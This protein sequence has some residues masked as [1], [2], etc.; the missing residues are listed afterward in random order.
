M[1]SYVDDLTGV[2]T[3]E[4]EYAQLDLA[5]PNDKLGLQLQDS[6]IKSREHWDKYPWSLSDTDKRAVK[7]LFPDLGSESNVL[8]VQRPM[9]E[10]FDDNMLFENMRA[11]LSYATGQLGVPE[12]TPSD[13]TAQAKRAA[14]NMGLGVYQHSLDEHVDQKVRTMAQAVISRKRG[15]LKLRLD[16]TIDDL[17]TDVV[18]PEDIVVDRFAPFMGDPNAVHHRLRKS[19]DELCSLYPGKAGQIKTMFGIVQGRWSQMSKVVPYWE[20]WFTY[21]DAKNKVRQG[22]AAWLLEPDFLLL[23]KA[24][25]PNWIYTG[26]DAKDRDQNLLKLPP[27][28]FV[29]I[30]YLNTG[31]TAIDETSLFDQAIPTQVLLNKRQKQWH[32]NIDYVN[33]RWVYDTSAMTEDEAT[34]IV[35]KGAK[36]LAGVNANGKGVGNY[37]ANVGA[38]Q[39]GPEVYESIGDLRERI[40]AK[41]GTPNQFS[42]QEGQKQNTLGRDIILKQQAGALQDDFVRAIQTMYASYY[43]IKLQMMKVYYTSSQTLLV[44]G[45]NN[46]HEEIIL[47]PDTLDSNVKVSVKSDSTLPLDKQAIRQ[48]SSELLKADKIDYQTAMEDLGYSDPEIRAEKFLRSQIDPI[49]YLHSVTQGIE[50]SDARDDIDAVIGGREPKDR[51][52]YD[53]QYLDAYNLFLTTNE[54]AKLDGAVKQGI[55]SHLALVQHAAAQQTALQEAMLDDAGI[56]EAPI[57]PP[58]PKTT[59]RI[60]GTLDPQDSEQKAGLPPS[61]PPVAPGQPGVPAVVAPPGVNPMK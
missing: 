41:M 36:T 15:W 1:S 34:K 10:N 42:G 11:I 60:N 46:Q 12:L 22:M 58:A 37:F 29:G 21:R 57:T 14:R 53:Q 59:V 31:K 28:P 18:P 4:E 5:M 9:D 2:Y 50:Q 52:T 45:G 8:G 23:E 61:Q 44:K 47:G 16:P 40:K 54:F 3:G 43:S 38:S 25:N 32:K 30:N 20:T 24:P 49:G 56:T 35:N 27:K 7:Y 51:D 19:I 33:G 39:L 55:V 48:M 26:D 13:T 17:I 6:L